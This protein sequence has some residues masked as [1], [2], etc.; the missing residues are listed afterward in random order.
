MSHAS[1]KRGKPKPVR[2]DRRHCQLKGSFT[3][4]Q[5]EVR[6]PLT[7]WCGPCRWWLW[8]YAEVDGNVRK[9]LPEAWK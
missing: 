2:I 5:P 7:R 8:T 9:L 6:L 4:A 3:C 1:L